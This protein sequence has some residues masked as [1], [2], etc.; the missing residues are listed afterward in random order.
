VK[1]E[2]QHKLGFGLVCGGGDR[3][4]AVL[5]VVEKKKRKKKIHR[6]SERN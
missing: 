6:E 5:L 4:L 1:I 3:K 2:R